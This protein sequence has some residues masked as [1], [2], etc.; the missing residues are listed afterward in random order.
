MNCL[1]QQ[2]EE[3]YFIGRAFVNN[4]LHKYQSW[5]STHYCIKDSSLDAG[6]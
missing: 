4:W 2:R 1:I 6:Q 3:F 5:L